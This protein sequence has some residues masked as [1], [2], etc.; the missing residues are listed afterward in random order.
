MKRRG[1][2]SKDSRN[3]N[4]PPRPRPSQRAAHD[5]TDK[6]AGIEWEAAHAEAAWEDSMP[7]ETVAIYQRLWNDART[8]RLINDLKRRGMDDRDIEI[9]FRNIARLPDDWESD[10]ETW[11][12]ASARRMSLAKQLRR[13]SKQVN[14]DPDLRGWS[15]VI[16]HQYLSAL[17]ED[18]VGTTSFADLL[19]AGVRLL[20]PSENMKVKISEN[21]IVSAAEFERRTKPSRA[22]SFQTYASKRIFDKIDSHPDPETGKEIRAAGHDRKKVLDLITAYYKSRAERRAKVLRAPNKQ[23]EFLLSI[24]LQKPIKPG[25][26]THVRKKSRRPYVIEK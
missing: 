25:T 13:L 6:I 14:S 22:M 2:P 23:V 20:E 16:S 12:H 3:N 24:L 21:E 19:S 15:F 18:E 1:T 8:P 7:P 5:P 26:V 11:A 10:N 9:L 17:K 4:R